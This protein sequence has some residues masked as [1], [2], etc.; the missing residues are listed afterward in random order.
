MLSSGGV[1]NQPGFLRVQDAVIVFNGGLLALISIGS[2]ILSSA[3]SLQTC[4]VDMLS[5]LESKVLLP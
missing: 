1:R 4:R 2:V 3:I 5:V